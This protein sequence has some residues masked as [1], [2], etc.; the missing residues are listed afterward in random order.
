MAC[1]WSDTLTN[2]CSL[3]YSQAISLYTFFP[4]LKITSA[5]WRTPLNSVPVS[6]KVGEGVW[7]WSV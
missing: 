7:C 1:Y 5:T 6:M 4:L 2:R 3:L